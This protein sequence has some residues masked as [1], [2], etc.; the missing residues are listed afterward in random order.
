MSLDTTTK[1]YKTSLN[2]AQ[3]SED[4]RFSGRSLRKGQA[5]TPMKPRRKITHYNLPYGL[6]VFLIFIIGTFGLYLFSACAVRRGHSGAQLNGSW[7]FSL[8]LQQWNDQARFNL[9]EVRGTSNCH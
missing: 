5:L 1:C 9:Q 6:I 3:I 2:A 4:C 8:I 7:R